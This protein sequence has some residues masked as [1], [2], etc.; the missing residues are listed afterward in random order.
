MV[1]FTAEYLGGLQCRATHTPSGSTMLTDAPADVGG[2]ASTFSPTDMVATG[3]LTC[4]MTTMALV[5]QRGGLDL[6]GM[7]GSIEKV[8]RTSPPRRIDALKLQLS[9]PIPADHPMV[10]KLKH[11]AQ[12]CPVHLSLHPEITETIDWQWVA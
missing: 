7:T 5:A 10:D 4:I 2:Q 11:A 3:L 9:M 6:A 8:M 12:N 1:H